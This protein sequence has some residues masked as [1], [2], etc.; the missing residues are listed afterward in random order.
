MF[1]LGCDRIKQ[2]VLYTIKDKKSKAKIYTCSDKYAE[3]MS[4]KGYLVTANIKK[5]LG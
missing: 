3:E 5:V 4:N 2:I 1:S